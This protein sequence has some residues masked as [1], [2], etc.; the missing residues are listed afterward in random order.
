M[1]LDARNRDEVPDTVVGDITIV[2]AGTV[3][4]FLAVILARQ[5]RSVIVVELVVGSQI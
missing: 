2:G 5:N 3:G 4:L 1:I